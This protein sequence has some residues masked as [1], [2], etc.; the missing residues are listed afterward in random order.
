MRCH[1]RLLCKLVKFFSQN[2]WTPSGSGAFQFGILFNIFFS[3]SCKICSRACL[4]FPFISFL[5][6]LNQVATFL[7]S[8]SWPQISI[9][10]IFASCAPGITISSFSSPPIKSALIISQKP[11]LLELSHSLLLSVDL[12]GFRFNSLQYLLFY[13][14][15]SFSFQFVS[16]LQ[17]II[18]FFLHLCTL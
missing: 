7:C 6:S 10:N 2:S 16:L 9:Q 17:I 8:T 4:F 12:S 15:F 18:V 13:F 5:I 3:F 14:W 11:V 1:T